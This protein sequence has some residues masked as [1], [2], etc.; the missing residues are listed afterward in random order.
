VSDG[1]NI[2]IC[3]DNW[4]FEGLNGEL[5]SFTILTSHER[6]VGFSPHKFFWKTIWKL[7]NLPKIHVFAWR[8]GH[9]LFP[10]NAKISSISQD[11]RKDFPRCGTSAKT[12][13][14]ALKDCLTVRAILTLGGL[15]NRL[16]ARDYS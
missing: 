5:L 12:L 6:K 15:N 13:I 3:K 16:L 14:H 7:K 2:D 1:N 9:E 10:M 4:G 8:V 11:F